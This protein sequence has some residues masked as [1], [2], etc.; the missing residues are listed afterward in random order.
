MGLLLDLAARTRHGESASS[1][2]SQ[3]LVTLVLAVLNAA[4]DFEIT[5]LVALEV[6]AATAELVMAEVAKSP[7]CDVVFSD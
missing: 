5:V 4:L 2:P 7:S 3:P 1:S 6:Q